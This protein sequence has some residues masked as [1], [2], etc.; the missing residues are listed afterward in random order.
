[1]RIGGKKL[2]FILPD[3]SFKRRE[4]ISIWVVEWNLLTFQC[5][6]GFIPHQSVYDMRI[7]VYNI[8]MNCA[9]LYRESFDRVLWTR[10]NHRARSSS[11]TSL[12][13]R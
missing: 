2:R 5:E 11:K 8:W 6:L 3:Y 7:K 9:L 4:S 12:E 1:M 10:R 13:D